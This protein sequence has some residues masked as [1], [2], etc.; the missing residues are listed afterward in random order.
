MDWILH[1]V[2]CDKILQTYRQHWLT[3]FYRHILSKIPIIFKKWGEGCY[4]PSTHPLSTP[5]FVRSILLT[6]YLYL[7]E[8]N[9]RMSNSNSLFKFV[10][11]WSISN[12]PLKSFHFS[13]V[14]KRQRKKK[15][16][17]VSNL[18]F[19]CLLWQTRVVASFFMVRGLSKTFSRH[20]SLANK[21]LAK[22]P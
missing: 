22:M 8:L 7:S 2:F 9:K 13:F 3:K 4:I 20:D 14:K 11:E 17:V 18:L 21:N 10:T 15:W 6:L 12:K 19:Q 1:F 16:S 5:L